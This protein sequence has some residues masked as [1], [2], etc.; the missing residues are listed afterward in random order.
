M[1]VTVQGIK[2]AG[3]NH[4]NISISDFSTKKR[5]RNYSL[6]P[7][8][9]YGI[10]AESQQIC[11]FPRLAVRL[12]AEIIPPSCTPVQKIESQI[13]EDPDVARTINELTKR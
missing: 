6:P 12:V 5:T 10:F 8:S 13:E 2:E 9:G 3:A 1:P 7:A 11:H 4:Y